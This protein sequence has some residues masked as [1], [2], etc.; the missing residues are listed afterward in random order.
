MANSRQ[1]DLLIVGGGPAGLATALAASQHGLHRVVVVDSRRPPIDK[2]CGEG[3]MPDGVARLA[4]LG[5]RIPRHQC[6]PFTGIR[7]VD[8]AVE[9]TGS[10]PQTS[11][12]GVRRTVL[13]AAMVRAAEEAGVDLRWGTKVQRLLPA[14]LEH[15]RKSA[16]GG[17]ELAGG[18]IPARW[19]VAADG[20]NSRLRA[21][22][23]LDKEVP[24]ITHRSTRFGVRRHFNIEPW[25]DKVEVHWRD[26]LEAYVTPVG[27]QEVG[28]ALAI[29]GNKA[30]F[31]SLLQ[32]FPQLAERLRGAAWSSRA[33]GLGPLRRQV[34]AVTRGRLA[35]VGDA[36]GYLDPITGEG[37]SL[38]FHQAVALAESLAT[39]SLTHYARAHRRIGRLPNTM[40][41]LIL[42]IE[43]RP[44]LR[45]RVIKTLASEPRLFDRFLGIHSRVLPLS[46]IGLGGVLRLARRLAMP[47]AAA[48]PMPLEPATSVATRKIRISHLAPPREPR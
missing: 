43:R 45:R 22:A 32:Q 24:A 8:G 46:A 38:A 34:K 36:S 5:V 37:L 6:T 31:D 35:L 4:E 14:T 48:I 20:L 44:R 11:G 30:H 41:R 29:S 10:F 7:Y 27:P 25:T 19:V 13:H 39:D 42:A 23:E 40:T 12:L 3:L 33:A 15:P 47:V 18:Q 1:A 2:P 26:G 17:V 9:A 21:Q 16:S 28:I